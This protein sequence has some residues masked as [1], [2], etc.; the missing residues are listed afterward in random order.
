MLTAALRKAAS[1]IWGL[2][3]HT[4][5]RVGRAKFAPMVEQLENIGEEIDDLRGQLGLES[6]EL[7]RIFLASRGPV[8]SDRVGEPKQAQAWLDRL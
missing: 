1:G 5:D 8:S 6:F 7:H 4:Q 3:G 2:F